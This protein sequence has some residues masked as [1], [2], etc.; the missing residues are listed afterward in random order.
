MKRPRVIA[1]IAAAATSPLT[2][3]VAPAGSGKSRALSEYLE[4][5]RR[6]NAVVV[7]AVERLDPAAIA[8]LVQSIDRAEPGQ[9]WILATRSSDGLP[10]GT[11][12]AYGRAR[13]VIGL[14]DLSFTAAEARDEIVAFTDGWAVAAAFAQSLAENGLDMR[15]V[16]EQTREMVRAFLDERFYGEIA[17]RERELLEIACALPAI[18]VALLEQAGFPD[19]YDAMQRIAAHTAMVWETDTG[20][21]A[22]NELVAE[23][24]R[25]RMAMR[26]RPQR[27][28][29]YERVAAALERTGAIGEALDAYVA[30]ERR[31][32][33]VRLLHER[34]LHLLDRAHV[35]VVHRAI[36]A[37][38]DKV[39]REDA[40][41]LTLRGVAHAAKGR[42]VRA[43]G[44]LQRALTRAGNDKSAHAAATLR[45]SL[46]LANRGEDAGTDLQKLAADADHAA[47]A[48]AEAW[49]ILAA[50]R[51]LTG[52]P[53]AAQTAVERATELLPSIERDDVR[54][55]VLQRIG[56][57][58]INSGDVER[59]RGSLE[60]AAE[61]A[62]EL[63]LFSLA[64]RA[65]AVLFNLARH[66]EDDIQSLS[67]FSTGGMNAAEKSG[68]V[69]DLKT[70]LL[71]QLN[72]ATR[73]GRADSVE[74]LTKRLDRLPDNGRHPFIS[75]PFKAVRNAWSGNFSEA[76]RLM[77]L[78]LDQ[79]HFR[80]DYL[81]CSALL[82]L[83]S[84]CGGKSKAGGRKLD[85]LVREVELHDESRLFD[86]RQR[87]VA[88]LYC[89]VAAGVGKRLTLAERLL[90]K[91]SRDESVTK[92]LFDLGC[93]FLNA[94][95]QDSAV[96]EDDV[97][98]LLY[99]LRAAGYGDVSNVLNAVADLMRTR[100]GAKRVNL[101]P[102]EISVL[103]MLNDGLGTKEIAGRSGR[104]VYTV[105]AHVANAI[106]KLGCHGR[107]EA[108]AMARRLG[109]MD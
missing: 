43:E 101:S 73:L 87:A 60:E 59:A 9:R 14:T 23:Y 72:V 26:E 40:A 5:G 80:T 33:V 106:A 7:D 37:L 24:L 3:I 8:S 18:D 54:A 104:S 95:R 64:S 1:L 27:A 108:I 19:A 56:V 76:S 29:M 11:W 92:A 47:E 103:R 36:D 48:R 61:L 65:Y 28:E 41:I 13:C 105:R 74:A 70:A 32:G 68:D 69:S 82:A 22:C 25:R 91:I 15:A 96:S 77:A 52:D 97:A 102:A 42:P 90:R 89:A 12:L 31:D 49:S 21:F 53:L 45:L 86:R 88:F 39:K 71:Q 20:R 38:D 75:E 6:D 35:D 79:I 67:R 34:G 57:A 85:Q 2:L 10:I 16:R 51:A 83:F 107:A 17:E 50:H 84:E 94:I 62:M 109:V 55:K 44:L 100:A 30:A 99:D 78:R 58:A 66:H 4:S 98:S 93:A 46:L 81:T 63:E